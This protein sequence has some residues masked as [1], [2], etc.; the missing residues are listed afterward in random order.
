MHLFRQGALGDWEGVFERMAAELRRLV[1]ARRGAGVVRV[2][3]SAGELVD[4]LTIARI[5][6]ERIA[7]PAKLRQV[8]A[9]LLALERSARALPSSAELAG[10]EARLKD[11]NGRLWEVED[12]I[13]VCEREGE[14]GERFVGLARSVYRLNDERGALKWRISEVAGP[15]PPTPE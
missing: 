9:E 4:R 11:V 14:F 8:R 10:L 3:V 12:A 7:D 1:E 2:E 15:V 6:A 5:K 13:R